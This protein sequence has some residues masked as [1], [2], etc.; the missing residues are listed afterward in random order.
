VAALAEK[1][2]SSPAT[3]D[4]QAIGNAVFGEQQLPFCIK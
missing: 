1:V 2:A 3:L 4:A